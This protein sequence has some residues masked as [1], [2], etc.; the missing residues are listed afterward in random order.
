MVPRL[1]P[2]TKNWTVETTPTVVVALTVMGVAVL[3]RI[4]V[5]VPGLV[6]VTEGAMEEFGRA[7]VTRSN[8]KTSRVLLLSI[9]MRLVT[10]CESPETFSAS[11]GN[12]TQRPSA[13]MD[14]KISEEAVL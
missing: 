6:M 11:E 3:T 1:V 5:A 4:E 7:L 9:E 13:L 10:V 8:R 2:F 12:A 14:G